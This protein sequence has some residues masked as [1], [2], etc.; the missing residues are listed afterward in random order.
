[1]RQKALKHLRRKLQG[2]YWWKHLPGVTRPAHFHILII[3]LLKSESAVPPAFSK[4]QRNGMHAY[5]RSY[6]HSIC[7]FGVRFPE[8]RNV[9]ISPC[10]STELSIYERRLAALSVSQNSD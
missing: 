5:N 3:L 8:K 10:M 9:C 4:L 1:M 2:F 7:L 6:E